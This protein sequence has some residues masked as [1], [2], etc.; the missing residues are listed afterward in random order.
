MGFGRP[1]ILAL[2]L[3]GSLAAGDAQVEKPRR[4]KLGGV[5]VTAGYTHFTGPYYYPYYYYPFYYSRFYDWAWYHPF[6]HPGFYTGFAYGP[7]KGTIRLRTDLEKAQ[8]YLDG[9]YAGFAG[10]LKTFW[11]DPGAY[12]LEVRAENRSPYHVRVYVP[13]GKT[14]RI[15]ADLPE[16]KP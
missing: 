3:A 9:A 5:L 12:N 4:V 10:D 6:F 7:S 8:V 14:L 2:A 1:A 15:D 16:V 11:L 13:S